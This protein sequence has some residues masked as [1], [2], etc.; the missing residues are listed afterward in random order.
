MEQWTNVYLFEISLESGGT[1][2]KIEATSYTTVQDRYHFLSV[3][4]WGLRKLVSEIEK[5]LCKGKSG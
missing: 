4:V 1:Q 2:T 3:R 5:L